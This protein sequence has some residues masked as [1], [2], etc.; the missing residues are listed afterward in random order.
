MRIRQRLV[1]WLA[2]L[3]MWAWR[4]LPVRIRLWAFMNDEKG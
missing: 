4:L 2:A 3:P 1:D